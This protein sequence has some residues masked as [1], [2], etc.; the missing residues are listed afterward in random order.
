MTTNTDPRNEIVT[1]PCDC[2]RPE[3]AY[4]LGFRDGEEN[5]DADLKAVGRERD[6]LSELLREE[7]ERAG[8]VLAEIAG[9]KRERDNLQAQLDERR[10]TTP[11]PTGWAHYE[12]RE[13][14]S[15]EL[16]CGECGWPHLIDTA[17]PSEIWNQIAE[18]HE[19]LCANC[20]DK[21]LDKAGIEAKAEFYFSGK[22]LHSRT[23]NESYGALQA[24]Q[25]QLTEAVGLL[26][27]WNNHVMASDLED[28][29]QRVTAYLTK[30]D[31]GNHD[32]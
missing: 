6:R 11:W 27:E 23:Y 30:Q 17:L 24:L 19:M 8:G 26:R 31:G 32:D 1:G 25:A 20:I 13:E 28:F 4:G 18:P 7:G 2:M 3:C 15:P 21:R 10:P 14:W 29:K 16:P 12:D 22:A 5:G 9:V